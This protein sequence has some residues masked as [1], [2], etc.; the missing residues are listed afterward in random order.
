MR[1][2]ISLSAQPCDRI[3]RPSACSP[4]TVNSAT[5]PSCERAPRHTDSKITLRSVAPS[6]RAA[7]SAISSALSSGASSR[8]RAATSSAICAAGA[9]SCRVV[10]RGV[11]DSAISLSGAACGRIG[12]SVTTARR[13]SSPGRATTAPRG[14]GSTMVFSMV[15]SGGFSWDLAGTTA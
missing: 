10:S 9:P 8:T 1:L 3:S 6:I 11:A 15:F 7:A 4:C 5:N 12:T 2:T 13:V 14:S